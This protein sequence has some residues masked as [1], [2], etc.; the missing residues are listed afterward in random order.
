MQSYSRTDTVPVG[1]KWIQYRSDGSTIASDIG[2]QRT[3]LID[4]NVQ[5]QKLGIP[6]APVV[7]PFR[8]R[9]DN[10]SFFKGSVK[11]YDNN[12][13]LRYEAIDHV[14]VDGLLAS[15]QAYAHNWDDMEGPAYSRFLGKVRDEQANLAVDIAEGRQTYRMVASAM[16]TIVWYAKKVPVAPV[17]VMANAWLAYKYGWL[18]A[19]QTLYGVANYTR[20]NLLQRQI[21]SSYSKYTSRSG[22][23][24]TNAGRHIV[25]PSGFTHQ[26][27]RYGA[28]LVL[29]NP[30]LY[31]VQRLTS[32]NPV[33]I[34]WEL[35]PFS[36]VFDW[37]YDIGGFLADSETVISMGH[38]LHYGYKTYV[39]KTELLHEWNE[40]T[41]GYQMPPNGG[42]Q[43]T[44]VVSAQAGSRWKTYNRQPVSSF[45]L[46]YAP[47]V[48]ADLG[49]SRVISG[50]ALLYQLFHTR[51]R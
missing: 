43:A 5:E 27:I 38:N 35:V 19:F 32:L 36:F 24:Y 46:P 16:D 8:W 13:R 49:A 17:A 44:R 48:Q 7:N 30:S 51:K 28:R 31:D 15:A 47:A 14:C 1:G 41:Y 22:L 6:N 50:A 33:A 26:K 42:E 40:V 25:T 10:S 20:T 39:H 4:H 11:Y 34:A 45:S 29:R 12:L 18:P 21:T 3:R 2:E 37:F 9:S 23:S